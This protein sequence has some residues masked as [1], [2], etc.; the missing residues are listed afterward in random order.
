MHWYMRISLQCSEKINACVD[1]DGMSIAR[2]AMIRTG[3]SLDVDGTWK[4]EQIFSH[5]QDIIAAYPENFND[6]DPDE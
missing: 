4:V 1:E 6:M 3:S 5:L 2:K